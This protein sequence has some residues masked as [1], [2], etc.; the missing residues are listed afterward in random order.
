MI[1]SPW[2]DYLYLCGD[3]R[4]GGPG[5]DA[6]D[7]R[8]DISGWRNAARTAS[9]RLYLPRGSR[10]G[11]Q[12][13]GRDGLLIGRYHGPLRLAVD[14][15]GNAD[16]A[17]LFARGWGRY[18]VIR[19]D[20]DGP[21]VVRDP[22][23]GLDAVSWRSA[24]VTFVASTPPPEIDAWLPQAAALDWTR[25][26]STL[27]SAAPVLVDSLI[28]GL[29]ATPPGGT[30]ARRA[31]KIVIR[32]IWSPSRIAE[33]ARA[34]RPEAVRQVV[35]TVV[36]TL[37]APHSALVAELSG[38]FDSSVVATSAVRTRGSRRMTWV[39]HK[40]DEAESDETVYAGSVA[41]RLG[42]TLTVVRKHPAALAAETLAPLAE[43]FRPSFQGVDADYDSRT[44]ELMEAAGATALLTGQ[45]GDAVFLQG[46]GP[47]VVLDRL[48]RL[49]PEGLDPGFLHRT[50]TRT[51][52]SL[53]SAANRLIRP[54]RDESPASPI[55][56]WMTGLDTMAPARRGQIV[57]LANCQVF[58]GDC[59]RARAGEL[60]HPLL[61]QPVM[62]HCLSIPA[63]LLADGRQDRALAR[64]A[65][66]DRLPG[67]ILSR[68][69]KGDMSAHYGRMA[70]ES[71]PFLRTLL[72]DGALVRNGAVA[73]EA[74]DQLLDPDVLI[75]RGDFNRLFIAAV[76]E[77]WARN[78]LG[79][80]GRRSPATYQTLDS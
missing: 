80:L 56:P 34:A 48:R 74:I 15:A 26:G 32:Q 73:P 16:P 46:A 33:D 47:E 71:L 66:S 36:E 39:N 75:W 57:Q 18:V 76:L 1:H 55:H 6:L 58:H 42:L 52:T 50:A 61:S 28:A 51:K 25:I 11:V 37:I 64:R 69:G 30:L 68:R 9:G 72:P 60:L 63:D 23:G 41:N 4:G 13:V 29:D 35:D 70:R 54:T 20:G 62:E 40:G 49:G 19:D 3:R 8:L 7:R 38:G 10:L 53:W 31:G 12:R 27:A 17:E 67:T 43:R 5:I 22:A 2:S 21:F 14:P 79:R 45:G 44:A 65:F 59:L 24:G 77:V 78:W